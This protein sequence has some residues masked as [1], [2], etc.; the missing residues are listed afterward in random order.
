MGVWEI[1]VGWLAFSLACGIALTL[2]MAK[3]LKRYQREKRRLRRE[4]T[5][6]ELC[7]PE[8]SEAKPAQEPKGYEAEAK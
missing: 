8:E 4:P 2:P 6:A 1:I 3:A 5:E 7:S